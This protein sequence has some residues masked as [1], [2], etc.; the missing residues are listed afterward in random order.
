MHMKSHISGKYSQLNQNPKKKL[1]IRNC[2]KCNKNFQTRQSYEAHCFMHNGQRPYKC[3]QCPKS[4]LYKHTLG[5][6]IL[7]HISIK[8][9]KKFKCDKCEKLYEFKS[10]LIRH[11]AHHSDDKAWLCT[12]CGKAYAL[13][14]TLK[15]HL[16]THSP[17]KAYECD[18]CGRTF[19]KKLVLEIH[20][21]K[22]HNEESPTFMCDRCPN[23]FYSNHGLKQHMMIHSD[24][25][26][27]K[28]DICSRYFLKYSRFL[29]HRK[30]IHNL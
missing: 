4:F 11:Y 15:T 2:E 24:E 14:A 8:K 19:M 29:D 26:K 18:V 16:K 25:K 23:Q 17:N 21:K 27:V 12:I 10:E 5:K 22:I 9:E 1:K 20:I 7:N 30:K 13:Q 6:H 28:C 3:N